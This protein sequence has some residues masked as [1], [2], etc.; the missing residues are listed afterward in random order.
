[1]GE[2]QAW[3][4]DPAGQALARLCSQEGR[5]GGKGEG[6]LLLFVPFRL[7]LSESQRLMFEKLALYCNSYAELIPVSFVLGKELTGVQQGGEWDSISSPWFGRAGPSLYLC[8]TPQV[9]GVSHIC[10]CSPA[11]EDK[12]QVAPDMPR[13]SV[14]ASPI[15]VFK[16]TLGGALS[17]LV[18]WK[19]SLSRVGGWNE[20]IFKVAS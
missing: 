10:E 16:A 9:G 17:N 20:I 1:M 13:E 4:R 19:M 12:L 11:Q 14:A 6:E 18:W 3:G 7:I 2:T 5:G 15:E 8:K